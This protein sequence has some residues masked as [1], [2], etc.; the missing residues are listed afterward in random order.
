[1]ISV[2][3]AYHLILQQER[4]FGTE[5][6]PLLQ[7]TG[8]ALA[9]K[10]VA[11]RDFP[12]YNRV[13]MD[14]IAIRKDAFANGQRSF[15]IQAVQAA[16]QPVMQLNDVNA[17]L[18]VMTGAML[19]ID[20]DVV[21][22]YED[23][24]IENNIATVHLNAVNLF[25]NVHQ[26]GTDTKAGQVLVEENQE[27]TP[28][29]VALM[30]TVGLSTVSIHKLPAV[31]ICATGD[32]LVEVDQQ[33]LPHQIRQS[34][35]YM[36]AAALLKEGITADRY[37]LID[38]PNEMRVQLENIISQYDVILFSGAVS[39]GK[40]DYLPNVLQD[41]GMQ[42]IFHSIAQRPGKPFLF[43]SFPDQALVFAFPGNPVSTFVCF[44][45]YFKDWLYQNLHLQRQRFQARLTQPVNFKPELSYH[46]PAQ[47]TWHEGETWVTPV[48]MS[49]SGDLTALLQAN[50]LITLPAD[51]NAW[52]END[53]VKVVLL[54]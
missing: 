11:D 14:G 10:V 51:E 46:I 48:G 36:L 22:R 34:N 19:P 30:A 28:G 31:A 41:L 6:V 17:C 3:E 52:A 18:E 5:H 47:V 20:T 27:I 53:L 21:I 35:S 43:G 33:P 45:L 23:C 40:F 54:Y 26:Q 25:Q 4:N 8:R 42:Q 50:A 39:K 1:M 32:E 37:H 13:M 16:G 29:I 9:Q 24:T 38:E 15:H 2:Q 7:A 49:G 12:P 44:E